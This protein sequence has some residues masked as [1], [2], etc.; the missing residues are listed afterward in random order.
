MHTWRLGLRRLGRSLITFQPAPGRAR[1]AL[2]WVAAIALGLIG[3]VLILGPARGSLGLLGAMAAKAGRQAALRRPARML[4][5][6]SLINVL[7]CQ[8]THDS[9]CM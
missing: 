3:T 4:L 2:R 1:R 7:Q 6:L 9:K 8:R 5:T